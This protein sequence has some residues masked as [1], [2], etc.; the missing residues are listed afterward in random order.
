[1]SKVWEETMFWVKEELSY[2]VWLFIFTVGLFSTQFTFHLKVY[3]YLVKFM[4][5]TGYERKFIL[6]I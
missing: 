3:I 4:F 2:V 1:M 6:L 5:T